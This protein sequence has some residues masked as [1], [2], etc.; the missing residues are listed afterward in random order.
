MLRGT[1]VKPSTVHGCG[2]FAT[3]RFQD[4]VIIGAVRGTFVDACKVTEGQRSNSFP[5]THTHDI[6]HKD[7]QA[8][9]L[10]RCHIAT[11]YRSR[12][13]WRSSTTS[14]TSTSA[15]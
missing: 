12:R 1:K 15:R 3:Q 11:A 13:W 5:P 4:G 14:P 10:Q 2:L 7:G 9:L 6:P 8:S